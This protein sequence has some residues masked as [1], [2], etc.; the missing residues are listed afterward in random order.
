MKQ[1]SRRQF[2]KFATASLGAGAISTAFPEAISRALAV[3]ASRRT[4]TIRDVEHVIILMDENRSFDHYYGMMRGVRGFADPHP[5]SLP[6]GRP[7]WQQPDE[8]GNAIMPFHLD[9]DKS[10]GL[11]QPSLDH[12]WKISH[13]LWKHHDAW[14]AR[15]TAMTM[16]HFR[17]DDMPF[18]YAL[19]DA[20]TICDAYHCSVFGPTNPNRMFLMSGTSG[21]AAGNSGQQ[22]IDNPSEDN[23]MADQR[24]DSAKFKPFDWTTYPERLEKAGIRWKL[25]QEYDNFGDN[26]LAYFAQFRGLEKNSSYYKKARRWAPGAT[27]EN[28]AASRGEFLIADMEADIL[29]GRLPQV[30]WIVTSQLLSEHPAGSSPA[31]GE[32]FLSNLMNMLTRHPKIW[33]KTVLFLNYDENDGFFDHMPIQVPPVT[34][35]MGKS[36]VATEGEDY[37]GVP[38]GLGPRVPMIVISPWSRGGFVNSQLFDHTS[39][40]RFLE[41]R[42]GVMEPNI[43]PWRRAICGDLT[44]T[45]DFS[46]P[47][48]ASDW[49]LPSTKGYDQ[50]AEAA[51]DLPLC[52]PPKHPAMP[53]QERGQRPARPI[54]YDFDCQAHITD[55]DDLHL[56]F[57]NPGETGVS[58]FVFAEGKKAGPWYYTVEAGKNLETDIHAQTGDMAFSVHGPNGFYRHY[59]SAGNEALPDCRPL[60]DTTKASLHIRM[61]NDTSAAQTFSLKNHYGPAGADKITLP[62][63]GTHEARLILAETDHWY[64]L[65]IRTQNTIQRFSGHIETG[66][67]SHSDPAMA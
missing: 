61:R 21:L 19:A 47:N 53:Q 35:D 37:H 18:H 36:T 41:T 28:V 58:F 13:D 52:H 64:D 67:N 26:A 9:T 65:E 29:A 38:F 48:T 17:R 39:V 4:G 11:C 43:T 46:H 20:F 55:Q 66:K 56:S 27:K 24:L 8:D 32:M 25:Y 5:I 7:V 31:Y 33:S 49:A 14:I 1:K 15:K 45:L 12:S 59:A 57:T 44:S 22:A 62:P 2:L 63:G 54:P 51:F 6:S 23:G 10:G 60:P 50:R 3:P 30:S 16:G 34:P 42:F 40:I